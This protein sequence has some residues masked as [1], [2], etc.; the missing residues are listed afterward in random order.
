MHA[1]SFVTS[2]S[3]WGSLTCR[4]P[5]TAWGTG[6]GVSAGPMSRAGAA[7]DPSHA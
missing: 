7:L 3:V 2:A 1:R 4:S 6:L 5:S